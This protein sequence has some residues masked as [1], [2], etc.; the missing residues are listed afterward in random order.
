MTKSKKWSEPKNKATISE[1]N[2]IIDD[3][4]K[5]SKYYKRLGYAKQSKQEKEHAKFFKQ[6]LKKMEKK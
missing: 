4:T 1:L 5:T 2:Y 3:E 6:Q